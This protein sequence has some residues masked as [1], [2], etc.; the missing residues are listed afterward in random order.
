M[1]RKSPRT[2]SAASADAGE[3]GEI[4]AQEPPPHAR[5]RERRQPDEQHFICLF[6]AVISTVSSGI[7]PPHFYV[8]LNIKLTIIKT[9]GQ[10]IVLSD[11][12]QDCT[13]RISITILFVCNPA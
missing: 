4:F 12:V 6:A 11:T 5:I 8:L 1:K 3:G 7:H 13:L 2:E 10:K 9:V